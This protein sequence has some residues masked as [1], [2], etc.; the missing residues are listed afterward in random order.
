MFKEYFFCFFFK[1]TELRREKKKRV[2]FHMKMQTAREEDTIRDEVFMIVLLALY[3]YLLM[4]DFKLFY[5]FIY[6]FIL[7]CYTVTCLFI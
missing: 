3:F 4:K 6:L 7:Y 2:E 1:W 5:L